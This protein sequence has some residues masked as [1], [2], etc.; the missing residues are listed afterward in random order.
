MA[1]EIV[2]INDSL[3]LND[4]SL[5]N[6]EEIAEDEIANEETPEVEIADE[7]NEIQVDPQ[8]QEANEGDID[9]H[10]T[11]GMRANSQLI[12]TTADKQLFKREKK[13]GDVHYY[14]CK[15]NNCP[16][17]IIYNSVLNKCTRKKTDPHTHSDQEKNVKTATVRKSIIDQ[18]KEMS[19]AA[20]RNKST[21]ND[22][23]YEKLRE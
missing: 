2:L 16:A 4:D 10:F 21:V 19:S 6:T 18:C 23:I 11:V 13:C 17:R 1:S 12:Y 5:E 22:L 3:E 15:E 8:P 14:R 20:K 9:F 7:E